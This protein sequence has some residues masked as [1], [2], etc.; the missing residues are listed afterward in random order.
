MKN[1]KFPALLKEFDI[2][3]QSIQIKHHYVSVLNE[4]EQFKV[5]DEITTLPEG[6]VFMTDQNFQNYSGSGVKYLSF[7]SGV[8]TPV[9]EHEILALQNL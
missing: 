8:L 4:D 1:E 7:S 2:T 5:C 9:P 3:G 6:Q